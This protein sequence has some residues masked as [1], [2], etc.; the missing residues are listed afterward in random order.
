MN[1]KE[2]QAAMIAEEAVKVW[3]VMAYVVNYR[4][5]VCDESLVYFSPFPLGGWAKHP[6]TGED[7]SIAELIMRE[8]GEDQEWI[9]D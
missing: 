2:C 5:P 3:D 6:E 7:V 4:C 8:E 9:M 1:C